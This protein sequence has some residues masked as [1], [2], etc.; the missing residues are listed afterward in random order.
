[1]VWTS[2]DG[3]YIALVP[4]VWLLYSLLLQSYC[5]RATTRPRA[6]LS[7]HRLLNNWLKSE[8]VKKDCFIK[9]HVL[10]DLFFDRFAR[11]GADITQTFTFYSRDV[12]TPEGCTLTCQQI[13]Q[14]FYTASTFDVSNWI[15][16]QVVTLPS[17]LLLIIVQ[18]LSCLVCVHNL[19]LQ[20]SCDIAFRVAFDNW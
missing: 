9:E 5:R 18:C 17:E 11:A 10:N 2:F 7:I 16:R 12:G 19:N 3:F 1:M 4:V 13:N 6:A 14:V 8:K 15:P 20:A